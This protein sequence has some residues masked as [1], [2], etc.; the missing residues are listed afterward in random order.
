MSS[1]V[2]TSL[3]PV[4]STHSSLSEEPVATQ[5]RETAQVEVVKDSIQSAQDAPASASCCGFW[6]T[7]VGKFLGSAWTTLKGWAQSAFDG[8]TKCFFCFAKKDDA[9][10]VDEVKSPVVESTDTK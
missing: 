10:K 3:A 1:P 7:S 6:E 2:T 8:I 5:K 4:S 9:P